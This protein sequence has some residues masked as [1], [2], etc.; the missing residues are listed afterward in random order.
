MASLKS[1]QKRYQSSLQND[2]FYGAEQACRMMHHRLTQGKTSSEEDKRQGLKVLLD[3]AKTLLGKG[4]P[5]AGTALAL[6]AA[7]HSIDYSVPV[8]DE[9][10]SA[11]VAISDAFGDDTDL[12][13][14]S[15]R[16][17][18]RFLKA[19]S[20]WSSRED[21]GGFQHGHPRL[22]SL[23]GRSAARVGDYN[24]AQRS[25]IYSDDPI[26]GAAVLF[27]Y[28]STV[29]LK[30]EQ[31][32]VLTRVILRYLLSE[33]LSDAVS[34]RTKFAELAGWPSIDNAS[35]ASNTSADQVPPLANFC[36]LLVKIVRL[37]TSAAP[38]FKRICS[39]YEPHL[40]RD[41]SFSKQLARIG[42]MYFN[43]QPPQPS[44][45]AGMMGSMLR[46]MMNP[47]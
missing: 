18:L 32:L 10:V 15:H 26:D 41:E 31:P 23:L 46:G 16:E 5:Q 35:Q 17:R 44:G 8:T 40:R 7:K 1:L 47:Q 4:Q 20:A 19:V 29:V 25:F 27:D 14:E 45:I 6:L 42:E 22:N 34:F 38:L 37:D 30:S 13:E 43:I 11:F 33:N 39:T 3:G 2:D 36:E 21:M 24:L 9:S 12:S 28:A